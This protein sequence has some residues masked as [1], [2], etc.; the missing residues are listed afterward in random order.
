V[1]IA[2][3]RLLGLEAGRLTEGAPA[4]IAV[5][6]PN[7]PWF[8][9]PETLRSRGKNSPFLG[10]EFSAQVRHTLVGGRLVHSIAEA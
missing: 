6:D 3:S 10:W 1:T 7:K 2:P 5:V 8:C 4:D 9:S